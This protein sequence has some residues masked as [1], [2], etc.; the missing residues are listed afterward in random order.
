ME[1][2]EGEI[3]AQQEVDALESEVEALESET[4]ETQDTTDWKAKYEETAGRLKR[5][6]TRLERLKVDRK[7]EKVLEKKTDELDETQLDYL[8]LKGISEQEDIA[9]IETIVKKTGMT[10]RQ[11]LKDDY[12]MKK[13]E[14]NKANRDLKDATPST[15]KRSSTGSS[16]DLAAAVARYE[17]SGF[18]AE[19]L[20]SDFKL[21]SEVVNAVVAKK[22]ANKPSWQ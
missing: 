8:D 12:V 14:A 11:A 22:S 19:H 13:L 1:T 4:E 10:V 3:E 9:V 18:N 5:E 20:P 6:Q 21:R 15:T 2:N 17:Q 16:N 7:V